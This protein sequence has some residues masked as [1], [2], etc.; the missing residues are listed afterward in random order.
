[1]LVNGVHLLPD[2]AGAVLWPRERLLAVADPRLESR[3]VVERL[4]RLLRQVQPKSVVCLGARLGRPAEADLRALR[5]AVGSCDWLWLSDTPDA[6]PAAELGGEAAAELVRGDLAFRHTPRPDAPPG[7]IAGAMLPRAAVVT[8]GGRLVRPCF[9]MDGRRLVMPGFAADSGSLDVLD[10]RWRPLF[11]RGFNVI[12]LGR[13]R[14]HSY[15]RGRLDG[16][17]GR[18]PGGDAGQERPER[19][20]AAAP[21]G[22]RFQLFPGD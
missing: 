8:G 16:G 13:D 21:S 22:S 6:S 11:R 5:R 4:T 12:L 10:A 2:L 14:L 20:R 1:M 15:P 7:E 17:A 18:A 3:P 19:P 9:V